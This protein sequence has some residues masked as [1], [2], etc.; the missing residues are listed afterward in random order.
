MQAAM[1][2]VPKP[3]PARTHCRYPDDC[4]AKTKNLHC[5]SCAALKKFAEN[6][7]ARERHV[8][9]SRARIIALNADPAHQE[10]AKLGKQG[11]FS[12]RHGMSQEMLPVARMIARKMGFSVAKAAAIIRRDLVKGA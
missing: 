10:K 12:R 6:P 9:I 8:E 1:P 5:H 2:A 11:I 7:Q 3:T 4:K